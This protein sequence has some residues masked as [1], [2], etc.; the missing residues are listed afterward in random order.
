MNSPYRLFCGKKNLLISICCGVLFGHPFYTVAQE[1][2]DSFVT[3]G[4]SGW[5]TKCTHD[6]IIQMIEYATKVGIT[7]PDR[8][9]ALLKQAR[10][11]SRETR[12]KKGL[13][14]SLQ[15]IGKI[16]FDIGLHEESL[17]AYRAALQEA[18]EMENRYKTAIFN[19]IANY[20]ALVLDLKEAAYYY[21]LAI[22][23]AD[24][25]FKQSARIYHN[26]GTTWNR[27]GYRKQAYDYMKQGIA[28]ALREQD[29]FG[30]AYLLNGIGGMYLTDNLDSGKTYLLRAREIARIIKDVQLEIP[31]TGNLAYVYLF[32]GKY[33]EGRQ[34]ATAFRRL[35]SRSL[36]TPL[37]S[38]DDRVNYGRMQ[39][40]L[41]DYSAAESYL[42]AALP[43]ADRLSSRLHQVII[44]GS[45]ALLYGE[46]GQ[47]RLAHQY[48]QAYAELH[49][50]HF[51]EQT[52]KAAVLLERK[53]KVAERE[54]Q[55]AEKEKTVAQID[56]RL[57]RQKLVMIVLVLGIST[58]AVIL[59][60][61]MQWRRRS[62]QL[63]E[64][65]R[66]GQEKDREMN[67]LKALMAGEEQERKRI[68]Q[69]LHDGIGS[70]LS[71]A[72]M[73]LS[74]LEQQNSMV[75]LNRDFRSAMSL[76][77]QSSM[78]LRATAHYLMPEIVLQ[79]GLEEALH[80]FSEKVGSIM[81]VPLVVEIFKSLSDVP[82][83][84]V[85]IAYRI[86]QELIYLII[87][88][89]DV[90]GITLQIDAE[91]GGLHLIIEVD[92]KP[93]NPEK[94][95]SD[96]PAWIELEQ[97]VGVMQGKLERDYG[98]IRGVTIVAELP[99]L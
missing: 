54:R 29:S 36:R 11:C 20:Y 87:E 34:Y 77:D 91:D 41:K 18:S 72:K 33:A 78:E 17:S 93:G 85:K 38:L 73:N 30:L 32:M 5:A 2:P 86:I 57:A 40:L 97:R 51:N 7:Y 25:S 23:Y 22:Q 6:D 81:K 69:E 9:L 19:G 65:D 98:D 76:L 16:Q 27:L 66:K 49:A 55:I 1:K 50:A 75:L 10:E 45:L 56:A 88:N 60:I 89:I 64:Q 39:Y 92:E 13:V 71:V 47:Y 43:E 44:L 70:L 74:I 14:S 67:R 62:K 79:G 63:Q 99:W 52:A 35:F 68:A 94:R 80:L 95:L 61:L 24:S 96:T 83:L 46:A 53:F 58:L 82:L 21:Y 48:Q 4:F 37:D 26:L 8:A 31:V 28:R 15:A 90:T 3:P 84:Q 59:L 12:F 42:L